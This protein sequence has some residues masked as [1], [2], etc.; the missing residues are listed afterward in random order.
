MYCIMYVCPVK[1]YFNKMHE[2]IMYNVHMFT[3]LYTAVK[4][5]YNYLI[6]I[7]SKNRSSTIKIYYYS[8][9]WAK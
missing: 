7:A 8:K 6:S 1:G 4:L 5:D 9:S 3:D 2:Y